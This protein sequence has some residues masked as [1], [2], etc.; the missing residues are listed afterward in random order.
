MCEFVVA[1]VDFLLVDSFQNLFV[2][3]FAWLEP[4]S[5]ARLVCGDLERFVGLFVVVPP[6]R[7][8]NR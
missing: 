7:D 6:A 4:K 1:N 3:L 8:R 2:V 5:W